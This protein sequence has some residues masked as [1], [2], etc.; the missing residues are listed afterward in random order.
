MAK[1]CSRQNNTLLLTA[2]EKG[3]LIANCGGIAI[4]QFSYEIM[5]TRK[6]CGMLDLLQRGAELSIG[7]VPG[8]GIGE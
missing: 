2:R 8:N 4:G 6:V 3:T 7:N 1:Q 5:C